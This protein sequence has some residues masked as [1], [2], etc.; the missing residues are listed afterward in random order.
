MGF[1]K[2]YFDVDTKY[3][4]RKLGLVLFPLANSVFYLF[5]GI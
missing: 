4:G 2:Y 5:F 1:L 3:V